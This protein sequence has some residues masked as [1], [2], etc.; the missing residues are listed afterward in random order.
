M[1]KDQEILGFRRKVFLT[2]AIFAAGVFAYILIRLFMG[3]SVPGGI[4][5]WIGCAIAY[6]AIFAVMLLADNYSSIVYEELDDTVLKWTD[7]A[8]IYQYDRI[9]LVLAILSGLISTFALPSFLPVS[10][11]AG[12]AFL[13]LLGTPK[14]RDRQD[15][16]AKVTV[17]SPRPI[18]PQA[19]S[20]DTTPAPT[21]GKLEDREFTWTVWWKYLSSQRIPLKINTQ[22][23]P[24]EYQEC[25]EC[26]PHGRGEHAEIDQ[27]IAEYLGARGM[28]P[29][30]Y[31]VADCLR[32]I[33]REKLWAKFQEISNAVAFAQGVVAYRS[34]S[35]TKDARE[36]WRYPQETLYETVGDCED[37]SLLAAALL[38]ALGH[39]TVILDYGDHIAV[40]VE[41]ADGFS[42]ESKTRLIQ[43]RYLYCETTGENW[44]VGE[45][46][47]E[48][49]GKTP[50]VYQV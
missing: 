15:L 17:P 44:Q 12:V 14:V 32:D 43:G 11:A 18:T 31:R 7:R 42:A 27:Q 36:Y 20:P 41:A 45:I 50:T 46:P 3:L 47:D 49:I 1:N 21:A 48:Q 33:T 24:D 40:G 23:S 16:P 13:F 6:V 28:T 2:G 8:G 26:N 10:L 39:P 34:D 19:P 38:K 35:D 4:D 30:V 29:D 25:Q 37:S 5:F 22:L 9:G